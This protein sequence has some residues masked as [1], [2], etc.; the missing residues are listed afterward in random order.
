MG[1]SENVEHVEITEY[2]E[3]FF[4]C[5]QAISAVM[6]MATSAIELP[7]T[8]QGYGNNLAYYHQQEERNPAFN[9]DNR[10]LSHQVDYEYGVPSYNV[11]YSVP[12]YYDG[13][14]P[15]FSDGHNNWWPIKPLGAP[16]PP[17]IVSS[18]PHY[19]YEIEGD[20]FSQRFT[21]Q[22]HEIAKR[23]PIPPLDPI[24]QTKKGIK[25]LPI[26]LPLTWKKLKPIS[27]P[28]FVGSCSTGVKLGTKLGTKL[29]LGF[30]APAALV[31]KPMKK[32][33]LK[34]LPLG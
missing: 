2:T 16:S 13:S 12:S 21:E 31:T 19:S 33:C 3:K 32:L 14:Q 22:G 20:T 23:S 30:G 24:T 4:F 29:T 34:F 1:P 18:R 9:L 10:D 15:Q 25:L 8:I 26:A 5:I 27:G 7:D 28:L 17:T 6:A 11:D